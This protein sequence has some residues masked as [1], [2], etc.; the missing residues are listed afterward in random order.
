MKPLWLFRLG[1]SCFSTKWNPSCEMWR[2]RGERQDTHWSPGRAPRSP[3]LLPQP[4]P[5]APKL[6]TLLHLSPRNREEPENIWDTFLIA[7]HHL[8][9]PKVWPQ[10]ESKPCEGILAH[11]RS[12]LYVLGKP[13]ECI[14]AWLL[15]TQSQ[16]ADWL[17]KEINLSLLSHLFHAEPR[18][19]LGHSLLLYRTGC[20][21]VHSVRGWERGESNSGRLLPSQVL[22]LTIGWVGEP[23]KL[24]TCQS[25]PP[26]HNPGWG[27]GSIGEP[28]KYWSWIWWSDCKDYRS[29]WSKALA[30]LP[31]R[32][33]PFPWNT[34]SLITSFQLDAN[35]WLFCWLR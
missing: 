35:I 15:V 4:Q 21:L 7:L 33:W 13:P 28:L 3:F 29:R 22:Q 34:T 18:P 19:Q 6:L 11:R 9:H 25:S 31:S 8:L 20:I 24:F 16:V 23:D 30:W 12:G 14:A 26:S 5:P 10:G 32:R 27:G 1:F 17:K 2:C